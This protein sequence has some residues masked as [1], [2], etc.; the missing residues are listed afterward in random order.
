MTRAYHSCSRYA[1]ATVPQELR[2]T[3][4]WPAA[5]TSHLSTAER[6]RV[7]RLRK[8]TRDYLEFLPIAH[9]LKQAGVTHKHFLKMLNRAL[10]RDLQTGQI[11][12]WAG[13]LPGVLRKPYT[14]TA[15]T[16]GRIRRG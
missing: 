15:D 12:G 7:I 8:I 5:N 14:R 9:Q 3:T 1:R 16:R 4:Q 13:F 10:S 11:L 2:D 6:L